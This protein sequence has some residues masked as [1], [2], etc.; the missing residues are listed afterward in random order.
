MSVLHIAPEKVLGEALA[1]GQLEEYIS[2]DLDSPRAMVKLDVTDLKFPDGSF[3]CVICN[4]VLE[5][6]PNDRQAMRELFRVLKP[7]GFAVLQVPIALSQPATVEDLETASP[8]DRELRFGQADHVR[9]YGT[10]YVDRLDSVGFD[11]E[12]IKWQDH[13]RLF[14]RSVNRM[15]LIPN[16]PLF[17]AHRPDKTST[18]KGSG[19]H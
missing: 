16:E 10:D 18:R 1:K 11:V 12:E 8:E 2:G 3:D 14:G 6:V 13:P 7:Q 4:H 15:A 19:E 5:H 17:I 9:L